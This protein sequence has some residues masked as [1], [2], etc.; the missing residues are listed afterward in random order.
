MKMRF[1]A[2]LLQSASV[3]GNENAAASEV[4]RYFAGKSIATERDAAGNL[5][6]GDVSANADV[7]LA[8]HMD[9]IGLMVTCI[10]PDGTLRVC[11]VGGIYVPMYF[12]HTIRI[13]TRSGLVY[14]SVSVNRELYDRKQYKATDLIVDIGATSAQQ[15]AEWVELGDTATFDSDWRMLK[16]DLICGRALDDKMGVYILVE[17]LSRLKE[18]GTEA[19]VCLCATVGEETVKNGAY[20]AASRIK[21][22]LTVVVD[23]TYTSDYQHGSPKEECGEILLGGGPAVCINPICSRRRIEELKETA[24]RVGVPLQFEVSATRTHTDADTI[25]QAAGGVETLIIS[26]PMRYMHSACET[27]SMQ[28]VEACIRLIAAYLQDCK[29]QEESLSRLESK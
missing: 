13:Y 20:W 29:A 28:D 27:V 21:P 24:K 12:G 25:H 18:T 19:K 5:F 17:A 3:S 14:G 16:N 9:E 7:L 26:L 8:A 6:A 11:G 15:A 4:Q 22:K 23:V 1:L 10:M 2:S